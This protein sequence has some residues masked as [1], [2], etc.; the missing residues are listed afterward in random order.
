MLAEQRA[1]DNLSM[2]DCMDTAERI[3]GKIWTADEF[4]ATD[5][6]AFGDAWRYELV[7]GVI[8]A[9]PAP[10]PDHGAILSLLSAALANRLRGRRDE[11]VDLDGE[12]AAS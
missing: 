7:D 11:T 6:R 12:N 1:S 4:L 2:E 9:H 3:A 8:I 5:Q 10:S